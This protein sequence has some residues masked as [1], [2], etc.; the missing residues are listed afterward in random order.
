MK[1]AT[2]PLLSTNT[3]IVGTPRNRCSLSENHTGEPA[4]PLARISV[5]VTDWIRQIKEAWLRGRVN[6]LKLAR[7]VSAAREQL[8]YGEWTGLWPAGQMPFS[9]R[10][11][12][13]LVVIG[14][15]LGGLDAQTLAHLPRGW[16]ILYQLARLDPTALRRFVQDGTIHPRLTLQAARALVAA[17]HGQTPEI[18]FRDASLMRRVQRFERFVQDT[19]SQW[20][21]QDR[22]LVAKRV[23]QLASRI[24]PS[25]ALNVVPQYDKRDEQSRLSCGQNGVCALDS[26][27]SSN[28][29]PSP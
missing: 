20:T 14:A 7:I 1:R 6:T 12:E 17:F 2:R 22:E 8:H 15:R 23:S 4:N 10:K 25:P 19:L 16:S 24:R 11:A 18:S 5:S 13:M 9:K 3:R 28:Q 29:P 26:V 27:V 21:D